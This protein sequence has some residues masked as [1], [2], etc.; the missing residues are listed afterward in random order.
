MIVPLTLSWVLTQIL[1][2]SFEIQIF[3]VPLTPYFYSVI[4]HFIQIFGNAPLTKTVWF[5]PITLKFNLVGQIFGFF[6]FSITVNL[7]VFFFLWKVSSIK[8][9]LACDVFIKINKKINWKKEK[10]WQCHLSEFKMNE[11]I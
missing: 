2:S 8:V 3:K 5:H 1:K 9:N 6:F 11:C 4:F 7:L 10:K